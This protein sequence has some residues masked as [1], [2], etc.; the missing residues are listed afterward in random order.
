[1]SL[2]IDFMLSMLNGTSSSSQSIS[3]RMRLLLARKLEALLAGCIL[4]P[5]IPPVPF[6]PHYWEEFRLMVKG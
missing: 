3:N 2:N 4:P 1:M 6:S 5:Y